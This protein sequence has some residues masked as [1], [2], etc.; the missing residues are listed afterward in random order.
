M[1]A[2]VAVSLAVCSAVEVFEMCEKSASESTMLAGDGRGAKNE[3][4]RSGRSSGL[5]AGSRSGDVDDVD[6]AS[7][8][9]GFPSKSMVLLMSVLVMIVDGLNVVGRAEI[10]ARVYSRSRSGGG[11]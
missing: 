11:G 7:C 4:A 8:C 5:T 10:E 3:E 6:D 2:S 1:S 9:G